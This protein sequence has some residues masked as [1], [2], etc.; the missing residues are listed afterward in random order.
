MSVFIIRNKFNKAT[1]LSQASKEEVQ[2]QVCLTA[3]G[4]SLTKE[5][6]K[7]SRR[8]PGAHS[9]WIWLV[10]SRLLVSSGQSKITC[11]SIIIF[12]SCVITG[13]T[14]QQEPCLRCRQMT[15]MVMK[16]EN[17]LRNK[18]VCSKH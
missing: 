8:S 6:Q 9:S 1:R 12:Q 11:P 10:K 7:G 13:Y 17:P 16:K 3:G 15:S 18:E 14:R 5:Q 2:H 4:L